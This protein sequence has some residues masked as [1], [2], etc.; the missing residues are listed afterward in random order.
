MGAPFLKSRLLSVPHGFSHR[1]GGVSHAPFDSLNLSLKVGDD[2]SSVQENFQAFSRQT[3]ISLAQ[4]RTV[5]QV[6]GT[7]VAQARAEGSQENG[8]AEPLGEADALWTEGEGVALCI[9]TADC[10]PVLLSDAGCKRVAAVHSGWRGTRGKVARATVEALVEK[11]SRPEQLAAA[12]GPCIRACCYQVSAELGE[13]FLSELGPEVAVN[14]DGTWFLDLPVAVRNTL[15]EC[16]I[17]DDKID[18]L[19]PCTSCMEK[20]YFSHRRDGGR[21]GRHISYVQCLF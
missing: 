7:H 1:E 5:S 20:A 3:G 9:R 14:R 10:V 12:I 19:A 11:G 16:G 18:F 15:R 6:H 17:P 4:F 2:P 21:T 13:A 8:L